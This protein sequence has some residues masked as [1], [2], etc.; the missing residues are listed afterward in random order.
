V[1]GPLRILLVCHHYRPEIGAPQ[2]RWDAFVAEWAA[3]GHEV[4]VL[5]ALPHYPT[6]RLLPG[7]RVRD[8]LGEQ[9]GDHGERVLRVPFLPVGGRGGVAKLG[10]QAFVA[11]MSV[12]SSPLIPVPD[13][14]VSSVPGPATLA[15]A[16]SLSAY[17]RVPHVLELRDAWPDLLYEGS[18]ENLMIPRA[19]GRWM[20]ARQRAADAVVSVTASFGGELVRRGVQ[21]ERVHHVSNGIDSSVVPVLAPP[22]PHDGPLRVLYLGTHGVS[23]G[24][25]NAVRALA[26]LPSQVEAR[27]VGEGSEKPALRRLASQLGADISFDGPV[28]GEDL[29]HTYAWADTCLVHLDDLPAFDHTVPSKLYEVMALGRH[30]TAVLAG[31]AAEIVKASSAG[32]VA[33]PGDPSSLA[34]LLRT[35]TEDPAVLHVGTES[36]TWVEKNADLRPLAHRF[37]KVIEKVVP[38]C[39]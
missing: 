15:A 22:E 16:D 29:W 9:R 2:R 21:P 7:Y 35:L 12:L 14:V 13:V 36:R 26:E 28:S 25:E 27:F 31:E 4:T 18:P 38:A 37:L 6:G 5:T 24:L 32:A 10:N 34:N 30:V 39:A 1:G 23:Q 3:L 33:V 8:L 20:T 19:F 11:A 17:Y